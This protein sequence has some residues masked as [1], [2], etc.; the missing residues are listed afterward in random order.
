MLR[1]SVRRP[2]ERKIDHLIRMDMYP[3]ATRRAVRISRLSSFSPREEYQENKCKKDHR[4]DAKDQTAGTVEPSRDRVVLGG[5]VLK[6]LF[7]L[8]LDVL[9]KIILTLIP[10]QRHVTEHRKAIDANL[11]IALVLRDHG[12]LYRLSFRDGCLVLERRCWHNHDPVLALAN[13]QSQGSE[14][15]VELVMQDLRID[16]VNHG[17]VTAP[18]EQ[19]GAADEEQGVVRHPDETVA[20]VGICDW[21]GW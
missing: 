5:R 13:A 10:V 6:S 19:H 11:R 8:L 20:E 3:G 12:S 15:A 1:R 21:L 7:Q 18:P 14:G 9:A 17:G 2:D 4:Y 16:I